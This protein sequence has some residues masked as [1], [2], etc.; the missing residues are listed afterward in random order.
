MIDSLFDELPPKTIKQVAA[1]VNSTLPTLSLKFLDIQHQH[2]TS[3]CGLY[4][5][6]NATTICEGKDPCTQLF[7]QDIMRSHLITC[8]ETGQM[9]LFP[10]KERQVL[11]DRRVKVTQQ[12]ELFCI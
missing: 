3:N 10:A 2:G 6:A 1:L 12:V 7:R 4:A 9:T 11:S 8:L 5:I